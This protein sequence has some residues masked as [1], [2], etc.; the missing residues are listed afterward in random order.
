MRR[1]FG[2]RRNGGRRLLCRWHRAAGAAALLAW[3]AV[4]ASLFVGRFSVML[5]C[6]CGHHNVCHEYFFF[7]P[8][9]SVHPRTAAKRYI[10]AGS[11]SLVD[12]DLTLG[13]PYYI[14]IHYEFR[15]MGRAD[16]MRP[17]LPPGHPHRV[18]DTAVAYPCHW[19][20]RLPG[21]LG[22]Y[23]P[24]FARFLFPDDIPNARGSYDFAADPLRRPAAALVPERPHDDP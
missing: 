2:K 23:R 11:Q 18:A 3:T 7:L 6:E 19:Y 10:H 17:P 1:P 24:D 22:A 9:W 12:W 13:W 8:P 15:A 16:L 4:A 5:Q 20:W 14:I 21:A